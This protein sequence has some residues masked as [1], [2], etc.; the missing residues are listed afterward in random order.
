VRQGVGMCSSKFAGKGMSPVLCGAVVTLI[1][2]VVELVPKLL[3]ACTSCTMLVDLAY[4][5][6]LAGL[7]GAP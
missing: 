4:S 5:R 3:C 7:F 6:H 1:R 2:L